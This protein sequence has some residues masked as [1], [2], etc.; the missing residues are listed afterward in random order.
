MVHAYSA[1]SPAKGCE[2]TNFPLKYMFKEHLYPA[3]G[4]ICGAYKRGTIWGRGCC[5]QGRE[6]KI[7]WHIREAGW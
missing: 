2:Y 3:E 4:G 7:L 6:F 5:Q 1:D